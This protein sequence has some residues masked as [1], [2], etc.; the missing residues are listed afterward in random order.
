MRRSDV[1]R[2]LTLDERGTGDDDI[3]RTLFI[4]H[5]GVEPV[6]IVEIGDVGLDRGDIAPDLGLGL[7]ELALTPS[8]DENISA[9]GHKRLRRSKADTTGAA[10]DDA[11]LSFEL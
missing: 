11:N 8:N 4:L 9:F 10:G 6:E 2:E 1:H 5:P 7:V 3:E